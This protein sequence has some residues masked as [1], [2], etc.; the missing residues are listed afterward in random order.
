VPGA[1]CRHGTVEQIQRGPRQVRVVGY[2]R[3]PLREWASLLAASS[4]SR[5]ADELATGQRALTATL[6]RPGWKRTA[7]PDG[8]RE[9]GPRP[10]W[11]TLT[12]LA[13]LAVGAS[14]LFPAGRHQWALSLLR[15]PT[16][17]TVLSFNQAS[18]LPATAVK[19]EP[20]TVSFTVGNNEGRVVGYRYVLSASSGG[21]SHIL[22]ASTRTVAPGATWTVSTV[23]RPTCDASPCR[24]EVWLPGHPET[25][26]FLV[27]LKAPRGKHA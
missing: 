7:R 18:A 25:I 8:D 22:G 27:T 15:Q 4:L 1:A 9:P 6:R 19:N 11:P 5:A 20:V 24:I 12:I 23:V 21:R 17:Y 13:V 2:A 3:E 10:W 26:D 14:L 16:R